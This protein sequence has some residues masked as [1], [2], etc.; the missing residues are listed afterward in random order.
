VRSTFIPHLLGVLLAVGGLGWLTY[1]YEPLARGLAPYNMA[2]GVLGE[3]ALTVW[4]IRRGVDEERW[5]AQ[6]TSLTGARLQT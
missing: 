1:F 4:L 6:C 5:S 3:A 2:L